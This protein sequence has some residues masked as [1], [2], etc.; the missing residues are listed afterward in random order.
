MYFFRDRGYVKCQSST[1]DPDSQSDQQAS[2]GSTTGTITITAPTGTG[3]TYSINGS[4]YTNTSGI[5]PVVAAGTY[6]VTAKNISGCTSSWTRVTLNA[7]PVPA[8]PTVSLTQPACGSTTGT[9]T[10][11]APTGAGMTYS[12]NGSTYT[13]TS[14]IF[15][16]SCRRYL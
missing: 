15:H 3:M 7:N 8:T 14:G 9:I 16:G 2:C 1:G 10:I 13:N 6:N 12:I 4:T 5:F 11:T